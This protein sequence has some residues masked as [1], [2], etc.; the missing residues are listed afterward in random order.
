MLQFFT[1]FESNLHDLNTKIS[2][3][4]FLVCVFFQD[5]VFLCSTG[6]PGT[7]SVETSFI[8]YACM[9]VCMYV[10]IYFHSPDCPVTHFVEPNQAGLKLTEVRSPASQVLGLEVCAM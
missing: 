1:C 6:H 5:R 8:F 3:I 7:C 10:C 9:Q 2:M 4:R